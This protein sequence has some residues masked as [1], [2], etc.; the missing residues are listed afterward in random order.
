MHDLQS[1]PLLLQDQFEEVM[2]ELED[3]RIKYDALKADN[4]TMLAERKRESASSPSDAAVVDANGNAGPHRAAEDSAAPLQ[5]IA[6]LE[7]HPSPFLRSAP[8]W[9]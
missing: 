2:Q 1:M 5:G 7:V 3:L 9:Q 8:Y 4:S 6:E